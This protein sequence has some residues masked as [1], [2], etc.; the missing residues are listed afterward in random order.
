MSYLAGPAQMHSS[1]SGKG[2]ETPNF[3]GS[4]LPRVALQDHPLVAFAAGDVCAVQVFEQGNG[5]LARNAGPQLE[6]RDAETR[7]PPLGKQA[8]QLFHCGVMKHQ[9]LADADQAFLAEQDF[10]QGACPRGFH[11]GLGQHFGH[12]GD[13]QTGLLKGAFDGLPRVLLVLAHH[14]RMAVQSHA[15]AFGLRSA[16]ANTSATA[17]TA[18]PACSKAR[19]MACRACSSSSR[20]TTAWP[21]NRTISPSATTS[22]EAASSASS[23]NGGMSWARLARSS[24]RATP[25]SSGCCR[26][27]SRTVFCNRSHA[28]WNQARSTNQGDASG[29]S[30]RPA[31]A[32]ARSMADAAIPVRAT[33]S[34]IA[35]PK[36]ASRPSRAMRAARSEPASTPS[37]CATSNPRA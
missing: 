19:S 8:A 9:I 10:E 18:R 29:S 11:A 22:C 16:W 12:C 5:V 24:G 27:N 14:H 20:I 1:I 15:F 13:G 35:M 17:G 36:S 26:W 30:T 7:R 37:R 3:D 6:I 28:A 2:Y 23:R 34:A 31:S 25:A 4:F 32:A 33:R 21:C